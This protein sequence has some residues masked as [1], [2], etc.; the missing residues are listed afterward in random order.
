MTVQD[1]KCFMAGKDCH[2]ARDLA[3]DW[4]AGQKKAPTI[5][6]TGRFDPSPITGQNAEPIRTLNL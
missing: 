5:L 3:R 6:I 2:S 1:M 4:C